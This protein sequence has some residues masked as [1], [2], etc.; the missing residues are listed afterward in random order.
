MHS[1]SGIIN[2]LSSTEKEEFVLFLKKQNKRHDTHNI[3]LFT[4]L[5]TDDI[6]EKN[7]D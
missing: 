1:V 2:I 3:Q 6:I 4:L 7:I 5:K